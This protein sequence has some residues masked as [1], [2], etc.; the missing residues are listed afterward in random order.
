[1]LHRAT[2]L[3]DHKIVEALLLHFINKII[4]KKLFLQVKHG[5]RS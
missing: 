4:F 5:K 1:M 3:V 2:Y